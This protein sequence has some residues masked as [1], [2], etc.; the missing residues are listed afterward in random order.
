[1]RDRG[2]VETGSLVNIHVFATDYDGTIAESN[3][4]NEATA[5]ALERVRATGRR[6]I[7]VTG[8]MLPDLQSVCPDL[9]RMFDAVVAENGAL[10]Y[11]PERRET[12]T[13]GDVPEPTLIAALERRGVPFAVGSAILATDA[14]FAEAALAAIQETG[15]ERSL[16]FN[17]GA[18]MLLPGGVTKGTG[19]T[20][21]LAIFELSP[22]NL[23]GIGDAEND[24]AFLSMCECAVA[25]ADAVPA[26]RERADYVTRG[27]AAHGTVEFIDEHLLNDLVDIVPRLV[28]HHLVLGETADGAPVAVPAHGTRMLIIGP[29]GSGKSTLTGVLAERVLESERSMLL[30]DPEGDYRTLSEIPGVVVFG[31]KGEQALPTPEELDQLLRHSRTSLVLDLSAMT[32]VEKVAYATKVLAVV[33]TVRAGTG[34]PHW[35][36]ID[37]AHHVLPAQGS[38]AADL[39]RPG[40]EGLALITLDPAELAPVVRPL[41]NVVAS[42][43]LTAFEASVR[44]VLAARADRSGALPVPGPPLERGEAA[45]AWLEPTARAV[46]FR[47]TKRRVHHRRHVRK[48]TEGE[49]PPER[50]FFFRGP[51]GALNLRAAN[52]VRF[53][54]LAEGVD[55]ATWSHHLAAGDYSGWVRRMIKDPELADEIAAIETSGAA[56]GE[57]RR[58]VLEKVRARYAV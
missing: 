58:Q 36:I 25:V 32:L 42:T 39:V 56:P 45:L 31:G 34:L 5:R 55:E 14:V 46:R 41:L 15:V 49:L 2:T 57:S 50:S 33:A 20:A 11:F 18:L 51:T 6:L 30:L 1:V 35:L 12:R 24:H 8:R 29:S 3:R 38:P 43:E 21:A 7:L 19:L 4:V 28:R 53:A 54:E 22:H 47:V 26:L 23:V 10:L 37:E 17:K 16:V 9:D 44:T 13:L 48:Y 27:A 40:A 52:L